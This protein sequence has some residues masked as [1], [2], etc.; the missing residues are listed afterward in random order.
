MHDSNGSD[1]PSGREWKLIEKLLHSSLSEQKKARR[2]GIFFKLLT[3]AYLFVVM[4]MLVP[5][6][7]SSPPMASEKHTALVNVNGMIA[8]GQEASADYVVSGL[9]EAFEAKNAASVVLRINSPGGSAVQSD[10]V[11]REI[12]RL[13]EKYSDKKV[14]AVITDMG[15]SGAYYIAAAADEIYANPSSIVG[16]I[17]VIMGAGFGFEELIEKIGVERRTIKAGKHKD[18]LD[19]FSPVDEF[20]TEHMQNMLDGVHQ[21][22]ID[23][24]KKG[25]GDR[26]KQDPLIFSGLFWNG[27]DALDLG[28][29]D[30][31]ASAGQLAREVIK[32]EEIVDYTVRPSPFENFVERFGV[33]MGAAMMQAFAE[34]GQVKVQ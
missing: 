28:L 17:G 13:K 4:F 14:Y 30:G 1:G 8:E 32:A 21:E 25:R 16:S 22:F 12:A 10:Y 19:P 2:W 27:R 3:F 34:Y 11:Y 9:R 15:A 5:R 29:I 6:D 18:L 20:Q 7:M 24:V 33:K 26:L 31:Y 23:S